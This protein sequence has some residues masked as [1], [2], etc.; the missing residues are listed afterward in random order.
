MHSSFYVIVKSNSR[1]NA[2]RK[3]NQF[4]HKK[5][6]GKWS[7]WHL[8]GGRFS[9]LLSCS[10]LET[11]SEKEEFLEEQNRDSYTTWGYHDDCL[12]LKS[13]TKAI[14]E[15]VLRTAE[16]EKLGKK[17]RDKKANKK[18]SKDDYEN[19]IHSL[20]YALYDSKN[21]LDKG[22]INAETGRA[23]LPKNPKGYYVVL[24]DY[25]F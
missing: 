23:K 15:R 5:Y 12:P 4:F 9:G 22:F 6:H 3:A 17:G 20:N 18:V 10:N 13:C 11:E 24:I 21:P 25:H 19:L 16:M 7:D 2:K 1:D 14:S 8:I